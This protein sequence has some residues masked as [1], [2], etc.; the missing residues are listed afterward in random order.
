M[1][2][3][4]IWELQHYVLMTA[5]AFCV[6]PQKVLIDASIK[7]IKKTSINTPL[8]KNHKIKSPSQSRKPESLN[9]QLFRSFDNHRV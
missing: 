2:G 5:I 8:F 7:S 4:G 9:Y 3:W 6:S 1:R